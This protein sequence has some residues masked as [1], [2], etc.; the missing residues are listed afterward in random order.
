M[1]LAARQPDIIV[2]SAIPLAAV[3]DQP[4]AELPKPPESASNDATDQ[5]GGVSKE[6]SPEDLA[7]ADAARKGD[8]TDP[9]K[10]GEM[11]KADDAKGDDDAEELSVDGKE[12]EDEAA[13]SDRLP[14]WARRQILTEKKKAKEYRQA[15]EKAAKA[16]VGSE[17]WETAV[18][19]ARDQI[20]QKEREAATSAGKKARDAEAAAEAARVE[21]AEL[22]ARVPT[23]TKVDEV[24]DTDPRPTRDAFDDPD[25]YDDALTDWA[26]R[27]G[28]RAAEKEAAEKKAA[29][30]A[31]ERATK[32]QEEKDA[33][34][35]ELV[36]LNNTWNER[37][38]ATMEKYADYAEVAEADPAEGGPVISKP[39]AFAIMKVENGPEVAY[40]LGQNT[41]EA[42]RIANMPDAASHFI[43]IGR[44]AER[45]ANPPRRRAPREEPIEPI[46]S[47]RNAGDRSDEEPDM[48][49]YA[50]KRNEA[51]R[52]TRRPF[53]PEG[54]LH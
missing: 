30:E 42:A 52:A 26:R 13:V 29:A 8:G 34:E 11:A 37:R 50:A 7:L 53:F 49:A 40:F 25:A 6:I 41:E 1:A 38:A 10:T 3:S 27:D 21:L 12:V 39:M 35:A 44:I 20:V 43:E 17:A 24:A 18:N 48:E 28:L 16:K 54:G 2:R 31:E 33:Q 23:E 36:K 5:T 4:L 47:G 46:D 51:L 9:E 19:L 45:L 22:K 32:E 15:L 14:D